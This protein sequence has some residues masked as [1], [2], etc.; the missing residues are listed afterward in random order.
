MPKS[1]TLAKTSGEAYVFSENQNDLTCGECGENFV[2][3][4]LATVSSNDKLQIYYACPRCLTKV[5]DVES[6]SDKESGTVTVLKE[7]GKDVSKKRESEAECEHFLG[8]LKQRP[9][10]SPIPDECLVCEK[11]I[12]CLVS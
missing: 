6:Q 11:M 12:E 8:Y 9:K 1:L 5:G 4:I 7:E 10:N 3:P 2:K